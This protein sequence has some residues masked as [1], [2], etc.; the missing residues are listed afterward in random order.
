MNKTLY[1]SK[2]LYDYRAEALILDGWVFDPCY[3]IFTKD[4]DI[5]EEYV[6]LRNWPED[7]YSQIYDYSKEW[8]RTFDEWQQLEAKQYIPA[9]EHIY[10][11]ASEHIY[12][13][14]S[15]HL[16][17][18][19]KDMSKEADRQQVYVQPHYPAD[20]IQPIEAIDQWEL[21]FNLGNVV[22]Y[23]ARAGKKSS[24]AELKDLK[25]ALWYL[26]RHIKTLEN[27]A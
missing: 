16:K 15:E 20:K 26:D 9:S 14:A 13:P 10:I 1:M 22:K 18:A 25:K 8:S 2:T 6:L 4:K 12:I 3:R 24:E 7:N 11:P 5:L 23:V 19:L 21:G 17:K 27:K